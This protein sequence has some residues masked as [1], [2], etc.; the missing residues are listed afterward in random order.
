MQNDTTV[1]NENI[2]GSAATPCP[3]AHRRFWKP[4]SVVFTLRY[5]VPMFLALVTMAKVCRFASS[6]S[7]DD[8]VQ[9]C[10]GIGSALC[11]SAVQRMRAYWGI[12]YPFVLIVYVVWHCLTGARLIEAPEVGWV[13]ELLFWT[14]FNVFYV[15]SGGRHCAPASGRNCAQLHTRAG[16]LWYIRLLPFVVLLGWI[17]CFAFLSGLANY[18]VLLVWFGLTIGLCTVETLWRNFAEP[19]GPVESQS[20]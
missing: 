13:T 17:S 5:V 15:V 12:V 8:S 14:Y 9:L 7:P 3:I 4:R 16:V 10:V 1:G 2:K 11:L 18:S 6:G 19:L 20:V